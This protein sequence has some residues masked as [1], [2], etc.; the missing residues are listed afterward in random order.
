M[1]IWSFEAAASGYTFTGV[2][3]ELLL[4]GRV[5]EVFFISQILFQALY[6]FIY[7]RY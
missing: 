2:I 3:R 4:A 7:Y 5:L 6:L 1:R